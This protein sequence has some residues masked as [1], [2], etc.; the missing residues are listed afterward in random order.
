MSTPLAT[1]IVAF[2]VSHL[3]QISVAGGYY[4]DL[5]ASIDTD[6]VGESDSISA[7]RANIVATGMP[8][9]SD[10]PGR[11][12]RSLELSIEFMAP[13]TVGEHARDKA[14]QMAADIDRALVNA[15]K[16]LDGPSDTT[17]PVGLISLDAE[18]ISL[19]RREPGSNLQEGE[20]VWLAQ[21]D[22]FFT[23]PVQ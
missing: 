5:G 18:R 13:V 11:Y 20:A 22:R 14:W 6:D 4:T 16:A 10:Q 17:A 12:G 21:T 9:M 19:P 2:V 7:P 1:S 15:R 23:D 8:S 3:S